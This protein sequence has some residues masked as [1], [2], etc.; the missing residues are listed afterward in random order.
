MS[1]TPASR[2][3]GGDGIEPKALQGKVVQRAAVRSVRLIPQDNETESGDIR[4]FARK[5]AG[6]A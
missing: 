1:N 4:R 6:E 3:T 5:A 2:R